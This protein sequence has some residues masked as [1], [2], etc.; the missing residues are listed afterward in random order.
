MNLVVNFATTIITQ[1]EGYNC[2]GLIGAFYG[3]PGPQGMLSHCAGPLF[4]NVPRQHCCPTAG[5]RT[6][7]WVAGRTVGARRCRLRLLRYQGFTVAEGGCR[8]TCRQGKLTHRLL[9]TC[10]AVLRAVLPPHSHWLVN[11]ARMH[12]NVQHWCNSATLWSIECCRGNFLARLRELSN[13]TISTAVLIQA[14]HGLQGR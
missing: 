4:R 2:R 9:L 5:S 10:A 1:E 11:P 13:S 6:R 7:W 12:L 3:R 8:G 14:Q